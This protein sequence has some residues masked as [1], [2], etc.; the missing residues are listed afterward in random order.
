M[1]GA[2]R[3]RRAR[4]VGAE[5][6]NGSPRTTIST[7]PNLQ[8]QLPFYRVTQHLTCRLIRYHPTKIR[9][10]LLPS[11]PGSA[12]PPS[13]SRDRAVIPRR[14]RTST[15]AA[16]SRPQ[17]RTRTRLRA[18]QLRGGTSESRMIWSLRRLS[19]CRSGEDRVVP[20]RRPQRRRLIIMRCLQ[21]RITLG[22]P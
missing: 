7:A 16:A 12:P 17:A 8:L 1:M 21:R 13:P 5:V 9:Q 20:S 6:T 2:M 11:R 3:R 10:S 19:A 18:G 14:S 4:L 15:A 22:S